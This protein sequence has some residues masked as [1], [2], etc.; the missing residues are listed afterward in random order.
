MRPAAFRALWVGIMLLGF[1]AAS[2]ACSCSWE[3]P[4][5]SVSGKA[6]LVVHGRIIR[7]PPGGSAMEVLVLETL[8]GGLLDSGI[9]VQ[10]GDGVH[11]RP[12]RDDF[13]PGSEWILALNG[14]GAKPGGGL[15]LSHCG[16]YWL[17]VSDGEVIGSID[18]SQ[19]QV[20]RMT[21]N[22]FRARF[23]YPRFAESFSARIS[24][25]KRFLRPFGG[26]F[27]F[28]LEPLPQGWEIRIK[29]YGRDENLARLTPP[30][31]F[32]PNPREIEGWHFLK[33]PSQCP[34]RPYR[35]EEGPENPRQFIFSPEIGAK[36]LR[37]DAGMSPTG[38]EVEKVKRFGRGRVDIKNVALE[39]DAQCPAIEWMEI[40]VHLE[41]GY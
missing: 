32:A 8:K 13:P 29:E 40:S 16:E 35:A 33:D 23:L 28:L 5:L 1:C 31:H 18:G 15:A 3:G 24:R 7:H 22:E 12:T 19:S 2:E 11:C 39:K 38:E 26:R 10:M 17:R 20:R 30:L 9:I 34:N 21:L 6:V 27:E 14:P 4:F 25:G 36:Y 37:P 41:G